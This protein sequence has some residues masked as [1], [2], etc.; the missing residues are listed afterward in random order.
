[1]KN[2]AAKK[3]KQWDMEPTEDRVGRMHDNMA[4]CSCWGCS[5]NRRMD[6]VTV[7][8]KKHEL[9]MLYGL[10]EWEENEREEYRQ[11]KTC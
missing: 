5:K 10:D 6:G 3:L 4:V 11:D 8:E 2:R 7:Q 1:M 9:D